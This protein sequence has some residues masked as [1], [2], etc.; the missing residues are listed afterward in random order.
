M[1]VIVLIAVWVGLLVLYLVCSRAFRSAD[2]D[3]VKARLTGIG[4]PKKEK[5]NQGTPA[6]INE[7]RPSPALLGKIMG[8]FNLE[9]KL[10][11]LLDQAG[12]KWTP[13]RFTYASLFAFLAGFGV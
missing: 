6:L 13:A 7:N 1:F 4:K 9:M 5:N 8:R 12:M 11:E 2:M 3:R 10:Q